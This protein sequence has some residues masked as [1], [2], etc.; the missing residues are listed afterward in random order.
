MRTLLALVATEGFL[1]MGTFSYLSV[2]LET[3]FRIGAFRIGLI[4]GLAGVSQ[5]IA[6]AF[7]GRLLRRMPER[8]LLASGGTLMAI[9]YLASAFGKHW[10][11]IAAACILVGAGFVLCHTTLQTRA[12]EIFPAARGTAVALFAFS[13]FAGSGLGSLAMAAALEEFGSKLSF[14]VCGTA[15]LAFT[16]VAVRASNL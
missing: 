7:L 6:A 8:R 1:F 4:L 3:R 9:A 12:T 5:L 13:L 15:L 10:L 11:I 14:A 2:L 16:A